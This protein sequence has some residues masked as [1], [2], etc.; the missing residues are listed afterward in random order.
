VLTGI[1]NSIVQSG[2]ENF[3]NA[4]LA[5]VLIAKSIEPLSMIIDV[6]GHWRLRA[7]ASLAT[8]VEGTLRT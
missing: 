4:H 5:S 6:T 3:Q 2:G 1:V 8:C 7:S